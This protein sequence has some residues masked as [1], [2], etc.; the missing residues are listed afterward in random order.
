MFLASGLLADKT[1]GIILVMSDLIEKV[2][3]I[4]KNDLFYIHNFVDFNYTFFQASNLSPSLSI[5]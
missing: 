3:G 2:K 1:G 5:R 4:M